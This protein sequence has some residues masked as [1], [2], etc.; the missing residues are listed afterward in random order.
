M[1]WLMWLAT[2]AACY[3][4]NQ[5][6]VRRKDLD[7]RPWFVPSLWGPVGMLIIVIASPVGWRRLS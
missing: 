3:P 7:H 2:V 6:L 5:W 1:G 4:V